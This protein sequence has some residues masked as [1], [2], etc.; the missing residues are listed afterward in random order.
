MHATG[1]QQWTWLDLL[2]ASAPGSGTQAIAPVHTPSLSQ[3]SRGERLPER[4]LAS[5]QD[6]FRGL[7]VRRGDCKV[8]GAVTRTACEALQLGFQLSNGLHGM[9]VGVKWCNRTLEHP[10]FCQPGYSLMH[11]AAR[12]NG[13][14]R[15]GTVIAVQPLVNGSQQT[16]GARLDPVVLRIEVGIEVLAKDGVVPL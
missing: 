3:R 10:D 11:H 13:V 5:R 9:A 6:L 14:P 1:A 15:C 12:D 8:D 2:Q 4:S 7:V 16:A